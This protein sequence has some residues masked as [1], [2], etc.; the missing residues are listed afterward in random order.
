MQIS[1]PGIT[2]SNAARKVDN[3]DGS[4]NFTYSVPQVGE[5]SL[6]IGVAGQEFPSSPYKVI[7]VK[8]GLNDI[9]VACVR[10]LFFFFFFFFFF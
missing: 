3:M 4:Y 2:G 9:I 7:S 6:R 1:G 5:Y 10:R 8:A